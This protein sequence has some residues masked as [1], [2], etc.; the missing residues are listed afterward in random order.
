VPVRNASDRRRR[1]RGQPGKNRTI[2]ANA[3]DGPAGW[4]V[5]LDNNTATAVKVTSYARP[6]LTTAEPADETG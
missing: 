5:D 2:S 1:Q 6:A 4:K 3:D